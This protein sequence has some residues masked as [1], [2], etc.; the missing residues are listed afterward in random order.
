[1]T[2]PRLVADQSCPSGVGRHAK[3]ALAFR[4]QL[5]AAQPCARLRLN[6]ISEA[7]ALRPRL[8]V[9][10]RFHLY[11]AD[12]LHEEVVLVPLHA[13]RVPDPERSGKRMAILPES[14]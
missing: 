12:T 4:A 7:R 6:V 10:S 1:M 11:L 3:E 14:C 5:G 13:L 8:D 2:C 9:R